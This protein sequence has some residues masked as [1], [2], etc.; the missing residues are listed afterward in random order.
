[1]VNPDFAAVF[2]EVQ[3][4]VIQQV[5][6]VFP[7]WRPLYAPVPTP[8]PTHH[9]SRQEVPKSSCYEDCFSITSW[10]P[11]LSC[12]W[13]PATAIPSLSEDCGSWFMHVFGGGD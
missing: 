6:T 1:M 10:G 5:R 3:C 8:S 12:S 9:L 7:I 2:W 13:L 11:G 4:P